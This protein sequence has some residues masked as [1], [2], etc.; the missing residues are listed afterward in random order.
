MLSNTSTQNKKNSLFFF[1]NSVITLDYFTIQ[2]VSIQISDKIIQLLSCQA[3]IHNFL[4]QN[5]FSHNSM[6]F[7]ASNSQISFINLKIMYIICFLRNF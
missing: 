7:M 4:I 1:E 3:S 2:D 5:T 6:V